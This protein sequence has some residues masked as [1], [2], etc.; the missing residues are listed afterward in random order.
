MYISMKLIFQALWYKSI[1]ISRFKFPIL[2]AIYKRPL[3]DGGRS[4]I[5]YV[6]IEIV[7]SIIIVINRSK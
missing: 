6:T 4:V 1:E 7:T 3:G 2:H 5:D